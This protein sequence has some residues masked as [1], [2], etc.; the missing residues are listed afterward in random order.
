MCGQSPDG[1]NFLP[2]S[3][4][5]SAPSKL[6]CATGLLTGK[7]ILAIY[8]SGRSACSGERISKGRV[9]ASVELQAEDEV[10]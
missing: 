8:F 2:S 7:G 1:I 9:G 4:C 10:L 5:Y 6:H 3:S